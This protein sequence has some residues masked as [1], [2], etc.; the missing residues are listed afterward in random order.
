MAFFRL[1]LA[2]R[3]QEPRRSSTS[4]LRVATCFGSDQNGLKWWFPKL[5]VAAACWMV[6][7]INFYMEVSK[8]GGTPK[9][10]M[11]YKFRRENPIKMDDLG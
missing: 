1:R 11:V 6:S 4:T 7:K 3:S 10:W 2:G 8:I 9:I 5:G